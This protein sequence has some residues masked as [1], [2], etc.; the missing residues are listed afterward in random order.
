MDD[1]ERTDSIRPEPQSA[2]SAQTPPD[3]APGLDQSPESE[4][5]P[6]EGAERSEYYQPNFVLLNPDTPHSSAGDE[7]SYPLFVVDR[8]NKGQP[9]DDGHERQQHRRRRGNGASE[10][11]AKSPYVTK[12]ALV[13]IVICTIIVSA[14]LGAAGAILFANRTTT[15]GNLTSNSS[16]ES[17]TGSKMTIEEI[18]ERNQD[19]VVEVNTK[20]RTSSA[21][22]SISG[23]GAG[24]GVIVNKK[25][26]IAT[27]YHVIAGAKSIS[28][29]LHNEHQYDAQ[30]VGYDQSND[31]AVLKI[32]AKNL[33]AAAI[34]KSS[35]VKVGDL[36]VAIGNPLGQ[37]GGTATSGIISALDRELT[38]DNNKL[39]LLQTDTAIN[40]GNSG[41]G[42]FNDKGELI[43]IV[44]A[45]GSGSDIEGLGF[46]IPT[47]TAAPI[48]DDIIKNGTVHSKPAAGITILDIS[49]DQTSQYK[50]STPGVYIADVYGTNASK[51]GLKS[52]DR[53]VAFQGKKITSSTQL[54]AA[55]QKKKIGDKVSMT[56]ER[57]GKQ[58]TVQFKLEDSSKFTA[59][60][61]SGG[62]FGSDEN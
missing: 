53:I 31:I 15:Y 40:P 58:L 12:K 7:S 2:Q 20:V 61:S 6:S 48:I 44:V 36:A 16:L 10:A 17:A 29:T 28:V 26:Y 42:L 49:K 54:I 38:I 45:K 60:S 62:S 21:Y 25:G 57:D 37:L 46:A 18:V 41:G 11:A 27:N 5:A 39:R 50:V 52:G 1:N 34:G 59:Q 56:V 55:I 30:V 13:I 35:K 33:T 23:E 3:P 8:P 14:F 43:G 4:S 47:D 24:S 9:G 22:G 19:A 51:A 32:N